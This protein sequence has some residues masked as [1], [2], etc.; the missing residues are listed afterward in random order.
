MTS[1][2]FFDF[3]KEHGPEI[4][5]IYQHGDIGGV[6]SYSTLGKLN[7]AVFWPST[8]LY[9]F[10]II[11]D[12]IPDEDDYV[13]L[14]STGKGISVGR[15]SWYNG[16]EYRVFR[17]NDPE[18]KLLGWKA[19]QRLTQHG[20]AKYDYGLYIKILAGCL[21]VWAGK[22]WTRLGGFVTR[23]QELSFTWMIAPA[24]LPYA[25]DSRF[26]CT[27]AANE[28]WRLVGR[29]PIPDGVIKLPAGFIQAL[30]HHKLKEVLS[31][32]TEVLV[33]VWT[34]PVTYTQDIITAAEWNGGVRDSIIG[35]PIDDARSPGTAQP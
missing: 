9:H 1:G 3:Q 23:S 24:E 12:Y 31:D 29:P 5:P 33:G 34:A 20:Q 2:P 8:D 25:R 6:P 16:K 27:E 14:E 13:I 10:F 4:L 22:L 28:A 18:A 30:Y 15:L 35:G 17:I 32:G 26:I 21:K 7:K 19:C 11:A